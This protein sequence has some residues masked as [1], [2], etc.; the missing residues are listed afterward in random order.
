MPPRRPSPDLHRLRAPLAAV[1]IAAM[2]VA[3]GAAGFA[4]VLKGSNFMA[5]SEAD[6]RS[7]LNL[8]EITAASQPDGV[9]VRWNSDK[10]GS[11]ALMRVIRSYPH[12]GHPCRDI[13][14]ESTVKARA[15]HF[16]LTY[17]RDTSGHWRLASQ[18]GP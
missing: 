6:M 1:L 9:D 8:V 12:D 17:C 18:S 16:Q 3:F 11:T 13:G 5:L 15:E 14:G 2:P 10:T 7:F 4:S